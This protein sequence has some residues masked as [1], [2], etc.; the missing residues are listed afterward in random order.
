MKT[1][2]FISVPH[3]GEHI[4][5][6]LKDVCVLVHKDIVADGDDGAQAIYRPLK[7]H[8]QDFIITPISRAIRDLNRAADEIGCDGLLKNHTCWNASDRSKFPASFQ[9]QQLLVSYRRQLRF[10]QGRKDVAVLRSGPGPLW[11]SNYKENQ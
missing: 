11:R 10:M 5:P 7:K 4:P 6:E 8:G 3:A 2:L 1:P 9:F